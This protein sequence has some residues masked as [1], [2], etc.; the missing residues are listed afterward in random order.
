MKKFK[1]IVGTDRSLY[2]Y[3]SR[4]RLQQLSL[5]QLY[6]VNTTST[7]PLFHILLQLYSIQQNNFVDFFLFSFLGIVMYIGPHTEI[8]FSNGVT[9][10]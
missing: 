4:T 5:Y 10:L 9:V 2:K 8:T 3:S 7:V 1:L 6:A